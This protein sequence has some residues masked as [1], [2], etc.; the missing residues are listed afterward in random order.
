M[1]QPQLNMTVTL[2]G[3]R[4]WMLACACLK[5]DEEEPVDMLGPYFTEETAKEALRIH[6]DSH[7]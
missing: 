7:S 2:E 6:K 4:A 3:E 1:Y 5:E